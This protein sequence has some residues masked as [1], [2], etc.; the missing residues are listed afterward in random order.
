M[1]FAPRYS[2]PSLLF[3]PE[4][5]QATHLH[6]C[7]NMV[8]WGRCCIYTFVSVDIDI[9]YHI[10][11]PQTPGSE[12][13]LKTNL[14]IHLYYVCLCWCAVQ[15][16]GVNGIFGDFCLFLYRCLCA[17]SFFS[18][19]LGHIFIIVLQWIRKR[20]KTGKEQESG[21]KAWMSLV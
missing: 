2:Q 15:I 1:H 14:W 12:K 11:S 16:L 19:T 6:F 13:L 9:E 17:F 20:A 3:V 18:C 10:Q 21:H 7:V 4:G 8:S 5:K